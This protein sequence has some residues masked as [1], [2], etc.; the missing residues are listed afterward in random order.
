MVFHWDNQGGLIHTG[1]LESI[2]LHAYREV[3]HLE[4]DVVEPNVLHCTD[5]G[6]DEGGDDESN[7]SQS[8]RTD[9]FMFMAR[10]D[11]PHRL[12]QWQ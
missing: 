11:D 2:P 1:T 12:T 9:R 3:G 6:N 5:T 10:G 8:S 4:W 7:A